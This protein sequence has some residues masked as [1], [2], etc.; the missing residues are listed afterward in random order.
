M[1]QRPLENV[2]LQTLQTTLPK[3][4]EEL[5]N[6]QRHLWREMER[7]T[8]DQLWQTA[9]STMPLP[10]QDQYRQLREKHGQNTLNT[11]EQFQM[12]ELYRETH[13]LMLRKAY[14]YVLLKWRG[15]S[16]PTLTE[17]AEES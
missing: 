14:A 9:R 3:L 7:L 16:L 8:D 11:S 17:L 15:Y 1:I 13:L 4:P 2:V 5:S 10:Q 6:D 12:E